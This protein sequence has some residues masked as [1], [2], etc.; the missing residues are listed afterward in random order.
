MA[1]TPLV[2]YINQPADVLKQLAFN[3]IKNN[4]VWTVYSVLCTVYCTVY[5]VLTVLWCC[6]LISQSTSSNS[7]PSTPSRTTRSGLSTLYSVLCTVPYSVLCTLYCVLYCV[8]CTDSPLVLYINQ[9]VDVLKQLAFNSIKNNEVWTVVSV[10][11][12]VL[13]CVL[14]T[15]YC[16]LC[17]VYCVLTVLWCCTLISQPTSSNSLPSTLSR[18]TRSG[19]STLYSVLCTLYCVLCTDSPLV[20]Y[21]NQPA[22]VLKQLAFNSIKNNEVS[23]IWGG[24]LDNWN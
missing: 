9:P 4:Q 10:L 3:S 8:L 18:T 21:I 17:T 14:C 2:L 5:C 13:Y 16:V 20:L 15:L 12:T 7:L 23:S 22:D 6:T 24:I 1:D 19:L 11:C